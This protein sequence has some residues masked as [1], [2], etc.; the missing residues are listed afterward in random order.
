MAKYLIPILC[1]ILTGCQPD[2]EFSRNGFG[3]PFATSPNARFFSP[4]QYDTYFNYKNDFYNDILSLSPY[5]EKFY[6]GINSAHENVPD[7]TYSIISSLDGEIYRFEND[8]ADIVQNFYEFNSSS[9]NIIRTEGIDLS[10][11]YHTIIVSGNNIK[12]DSLKAFVP[13]FYDLAVTDVTGSVGSVKIEWTPYSGDSTFS[14]YHLVASRLVEDMGSPK[15]FKHSII[16]QI[17]TIN[18]TTFLDTINYSGSPVFYSIR[19]IFSGGDSIRSN[20]V[21]FNPQ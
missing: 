4:V 8:V 20:S 5:K 18:S 11:G 3:D 6:V 12:L 13:D 14:Y 9:K 7:L 2:P 16:A 10:P 15:P 21:E 1:L 19:A 17:N